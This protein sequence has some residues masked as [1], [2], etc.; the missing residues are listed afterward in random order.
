MLDECLSNTNN[1]YYNDIP[2]KDK[3]TE[4]VIHKRRK[5]TEKGTAQTS[6]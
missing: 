1:D 5:K 2:L 4:D 6:F 3:G